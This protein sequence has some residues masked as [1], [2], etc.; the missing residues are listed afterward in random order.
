MI[1]AYNSHKEIVKL[2]IDKNA[3]V[4]IRDCFD[5]TALDRSKDSYIIKMLQEAAEVGQEYDEKNEDQTQETKPEQ[6]S[7]TP[8]QP[9]SKEQLHS[10]L[11]K[12]GTKRDEYSRY[13]D[14]DY[15]K[16][17]DFNSQ[18]NHTTASSIYH[19]QRPQEQRGNERRLHSPSKQDISTLHN[20]SRMSRDY[21]PL[22][23][24]L[25]SKMSYIDLGVK[26]IFRSKVI[27]KI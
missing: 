26:K 23:R 4:T 19:Y 3:N 18:P 15:V 5:K 13:A 8:E 14:D 22:V 25:F 11:K 6:H 17:Q 16:V 7:L 27:N 9:N 24:I 12:S 10:I 20:D 2:L 21:N 1:A